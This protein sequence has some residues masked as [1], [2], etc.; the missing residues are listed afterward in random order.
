MRAARAAVVGEAVGALSVV[1]RGEV[2][3]LAEEKVGAVLDRR[4]GELRETSGGLRYLADAAQSLVG[5]EEGS[6][7]YRRETVIVTS[8]DRLVRELDGREAS[9]RASAAGAEVLQSVQERHAAEYGPVPTL[10]QRE[11]QVET[12]EV[13]L[14]KRREEEARRD[15]AAAAER[16]EAERRQAEARRRAAVAGL[17]TTIRATKQGPGWL[18]EAQRR[19]LQGADRQPTLA[20]RERIA[21]TVKRWIREDLDRHKRKLGATEDGAWFL[22]E[23]LRSAGAVTTLAAEEQL[24]ETAKKELH[25]FQAAEARRSAREQELF[26]QPGGED[27]R[28]AV[29]TGL[30][31]QWRDSGESAVVNFETALETAESDSDRRGRLRDVLADPAGAVRYREA[32]EARG[33]QFTVQDIDA[34]VDAVLR[35]RAAAE[36]RRQAEEQQR[37]ELDRREAQVRATSAGEQR[38][39]KEQS[40]RFGAKRSLTLDEKLSVVE[41]VEMEIRQELDAREVAIKAEAGGGELLQRV[42]GRRGAPRDL[43]AREE[44]IEDVEQ[45][46]R[47]T[48]EVETQLPTTLDPERRGCRVSVVF[49]AMLNAVLADDDDPFVGDVVFLLGARYAQRALKGVAEGGYDAAAREE[50]ARRHFGSAVVDA[51]KWCVQ[52]VREIIL[53]AC[54]KILG[55]GGESGERVQASL[56][57][58]RAER[59]AQQSAVESAAQ[60]VAIDVDA[61]SQSAL[62]DGRDPV[63]ALEEATAPRR[64]VLKEAKAAGVDFQKVFAEAEEKQKD[65]GFAAIEAV[66]NEL[67][68]NLKRRKWSAWRFPGGKE[69][70]LAEEQKILR[71]A[72]RPLTPPE[73]DTA[74]SAVEAWV[75]GE[76]RDHVRRVVAEMRAE[77]GFVP[78]AGVVR[79]AGRALREQY[80]PEHRPGRLVSALKQ[81]PDETGAPPSD[82]LHAALNDQRLAKHAARNMEDLERYQ[83]ALKRWKQDHTLSWSGWSAGYPK[84][85]KPK[86][87][88]DPAPPSQEQIERFQKELIAGGG[89]V[90]PPVGQ[91]GVRDLGARWRRQ[92]TRR[93]A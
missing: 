46:S 51:M 90:R 78:P 7:L 87:E 37:R 64:K 21:G 28:D 89:S 15:R 39:K 63:S 33:E 31:P 57:G 83:Q 69:R 61:F 16:Q 48:D 30:D 4:A 22:D 2:V 65:S 20:E 84:P 81:L 8:E 17:E 5:V 9:L 86:K 42:E 34:A 68:S 52:K 41:T 80:D 14:G 24:V 54:H 19:V 58:A 75:E 88:P 77:F 35:E 85:K 92:D 56:E 44:M 55:S 49:D 23:A 40:A 76:M 12:A 43:A 3:E 13:L 59:Q 11:R 71:G 79:A 1:Q 45:V 91:A 72:S 32:L 67:V 27:L 6:A 25:E 74:V 38:L 66:T 26:A 29:L 60:K 36:A 53:A 82:V 62:G 18:S 73:R 93:I 10:A 50:S 47:A 70:L